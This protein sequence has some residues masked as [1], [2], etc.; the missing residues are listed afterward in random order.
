MKKIFFTFLLSL[1]FSSNVFAESYYFKNCS[2][3]NAVS[4]DYIINIDNKVIDV[5]LR[6]ID[7]TVQ[8]FSDKIKSIE[9]GKI[10]SKKIKSQKGDNIYF[11]Y[12]L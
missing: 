9:K 11:Q 3:S 6:A 1:F 7:G 10:I 4:G 12:F 2:L 5:S 8:N